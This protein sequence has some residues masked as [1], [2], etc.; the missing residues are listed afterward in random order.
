MYDKVPIDAQSF[1]LT[2]H[3]NALLNE[4][5]LD[6]RDEVATLRAQLAERDKAWEEMQEHIIGIRN[7]I[8]T[9]EMMAMATDGPVA[10]T[11]DVMDTADLERTLRHAW[12]LTEII[13][14]HAPKE[15]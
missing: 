11:S 6:L 4:K 15:G 1:T 12:Q 8:T 13:D 3:E 7:T 10:L 2:L 14:R 5:L 9:A